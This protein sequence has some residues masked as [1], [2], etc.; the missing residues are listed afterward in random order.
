MLKLPKDNFVFLETNKFDKDNSR[1]FLFS[2]PTKIIS[3][4]ELK[5]VKSA[6]FELE[7]YISKGYYAAGFVTYEAGFSFEEQLKN[8]NLDSEFPLLWF[9]IY[10]KPLIVTH[11]EK[12]ALLQNKKSPYTI[13]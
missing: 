7:D 10:K 6:F 1:S 4:Y 3:C 2:N 5:D 9:G 12:I 8:L 11:K 13:F